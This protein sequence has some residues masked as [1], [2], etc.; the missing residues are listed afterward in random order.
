MAEMM[1]NSIVMS[2]V[3]HFGFHSYGGSAGNADSA[4]KGSSYASRNFWMTELS[5]PEQIF[6]LIGQGTAGTQI[7][8]AYDSV[9][10]HAILAGA[11]YNDGRGTTPPNDAGNGPAL[12]SYNSTTGTY[13]RRQ[14]F[15]MAQTFKYVSPGSIRIGPTE[16]NSS[17]TVYAFRHPTTGRVTIVGRNTSS[18]SVAI[19]GTLSGVGSVSS[20]QFYQTG[21]S[22]NYNSFPR[23]ADV[24]VTN[25]TLVFTAPANS[26]FTL[27]SGQ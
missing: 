5:I 17:L 12:L 7:W 6:S 2:K 26:Y 8:D 19:T 4:I 11:H 9:Y 13:A 20:F 1:G 27:T 22:D 23:G 14:Q 10:N 15:Y 3:D 18:G 24:V 25:G 21:I 16:S